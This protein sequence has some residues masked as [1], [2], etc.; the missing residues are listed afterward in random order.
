MQG[1]PIKNV[2]LSKSNCL[3]PILKLICNWLNSIKIL[4]QCFKTN[5]IGAGTPNDLKFLYPNIF[6]SVVQVL[7]PFWS[8]SYIRVIMM[9][10]LQ[11]LSPD[12]WYFCNGIFDAGSSNQS[13]NNEYKSH[14]CLSFCHSTNLMIHCHCHSTNYLDGGKF[15]V[16]LSFV[17]LVQLGKERVLI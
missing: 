9:P 10:F 5:N 3:H 16:S 12:F 1:A 8:L 7:T 13:I 15:W 6:S 2:K 4:L 14:L 17:W 11:I